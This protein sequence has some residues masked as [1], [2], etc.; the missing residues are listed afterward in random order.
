[1]DMHEESY[2][3][4]IQISEQH[5]NWLANKYGTTKWTTKQAPLK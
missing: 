1:M 3:L 4:Y 2:S 5:I